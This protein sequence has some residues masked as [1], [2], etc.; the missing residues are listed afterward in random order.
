DWK[1]FGVD[2]NKGDGG[3]G[4]DDPQPEIIGDV[5]ENGK[6]DIVDF[7]LLKKFVLGEDVQLSTTAAD[8]NEDGKLNSIDI[9]LLLNSLLFANK[10]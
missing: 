8:M 2:G 5:D 4:G 9:S 7:V 1:T 10:A 3:D 6:F